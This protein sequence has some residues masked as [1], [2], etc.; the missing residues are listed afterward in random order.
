VAR[1]TGVITKNNKGRETK[2]VQDGSTEIAA[3]ITAVSPPMA[4]EIK[5]H[6]ISGE[7]RAWDKTGGCAPGPNLNPPLNI[8]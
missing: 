3:P 6:V 2:G 8:T 4:T 1:R 5:S 7:E